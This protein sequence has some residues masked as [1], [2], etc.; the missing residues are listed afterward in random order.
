MQ[1]I[2]YT[3]FYATLRVII[4]SLVIGLAL[5]GNI[6]GPILYV[7]LYN[8]PNYL[9]RYFGCVYGYRLGSTY[10]TEAAKT[11]LLDCITK[12]ASL[13][14]IGV[15]CHTSQEDQPQLVPSRTG[16]IWF[17]SDI[18]S[19]GIRKTGNTGFRGAGPVFPFCH[20][21]PVCDIIVRYSNRVKKR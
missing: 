3:F 19:F 21:S 11:G 6:M 4:T 16:G 8:I 1:G 5:N 13:L 7:L 12:A 10:I 15:F 9:I 14:G 17:C 18:P 2:G 20:L